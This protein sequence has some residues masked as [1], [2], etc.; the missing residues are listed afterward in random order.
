MALFCTYTAT[1]QVTRVLYRGPETFSPCSCSA[2]DLD[3]D[4]VIEMELL[5]PLDGD[6]FL[7]T[8]EPRVRSFVRLNDP[9]VK[10]DTGKFVL[11][12]TL[13]TGSWSR[14]V[15]A[16]GLSGTQARINKDVMSVL[17]VR[18]LVE[19]CRSRPEND[20]WITL[21]RVLHSFD[22]PDET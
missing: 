2:N 19:E 12:R 1:G 22:T 3:Y 8:K 6:N 21:S 4:L 9:R 16:L 17:D 18:K 20:R 10:S 11:S 7:V 13:Q 14:L 5:S 15:S